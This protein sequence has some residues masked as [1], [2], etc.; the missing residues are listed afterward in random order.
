MQP[1]VYGRNFPALSK[2]TKCRSDDEGR[3]L[4]SERICRWVICA[5]LFSREFRALFLFLK[6]KHSE[7][8]NSKIFRIPL[9]QHFPSQGQDNRESQRVQRRRKVHVLHSCRRRLQGEMNKKTNYFF[10]SLC[11]KFFCLE[12]SIKTRVRLLHQS[13]REKP[14]IYNR[15][16]FFRHIAKSGFTSATAGYFLKSRALVRRKRDPTNVSE[17]SSKKVVARKYD[18]WPEIFQ[19]LRTVSG[20]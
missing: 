4:S 12:P 11:S 3:I 1:F 20:R 6:K 2:C 14:F 16:T 15:N 18:L 17:S 7:R 13:D 9:L 19:I 5:I 10:F 8:G